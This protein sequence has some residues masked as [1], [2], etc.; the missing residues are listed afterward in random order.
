MAL[1][2]VSS[3]LISSVANTAITGN[4]ISGQITSVANTQITGVLNSSQLANTGVSAGIY[5]GA[6]QIPVIC[7]NNQGQL[8]SVSNSSITLGTIATQNYSNVCITGGNVCANYVCSNT[9]MIAPIICAS[10]CI[11]SPIICA[12]TCFVGS[13][14]GITGINTLGGGS[15][16]TCSSTSYTLTSA[17]CRAIGLCF[18]SLPSIACL[19]LPNATTINSGSPAY[20]VKNLNPST[21]VLVQDSCFCTVGYI[22]SCQVGEISLYNNSQAQGNWAVINSGVSSCV[23]NSTINCYWPAGFSSASCTSF[24]DANNKI[25]TVIWSCILPCVCTITYAP[26]ASGYNVTSTSFTT[27]GCRCACVGIQTINFSYVFQTPD[28]FILIENRYSGTCRALANNYSNTTVFYVIN[29]DS[30]SYTKFT[31]N[32]L[33]NTSFCG[34]G[35]CTFC[36][37]G[38]SSY[39]SQYTCVFN[40]HIHLV[41]YGYTCSGNTCLLHLDRVYYTVTGTTGTP[42]MCSVFTYCSFDSWLCTCGGGTPFCGTAMLT[43]TVGWCSVPNRIATMYQQVWTSNSASYI[44]NPVTTGFYA[45]PIAHKLFCYYAN[46]CVSLSCVPYNSALDNGTFNCYNTYA[47]TIGIA[48]I[49]Y[50]AQGMFM[51]NICGTPIITFGGGCY[52]GVVTA[53]STGYYC[54]SCIGI[55]CSVAAGYECLFQLN[56][57]TANS[58]LFFVHGTNSFC[59][60]IFRGDFYE[61]CC[62]CPKPLNCLTASSFT[63]GSNQHLCCCCYSEPWVGIF[64]GS[65][66]PTCSPGGRYNYAYHYGDKDRG[67]TLANPGCTCC[68]QC[69]TPTYLLYCDTPTCAVFYGQGNCCAPGFT[70]L[71]IWTYAPGTA[72]V[73]GCSIYLN[74]LNTCASCACCSYNIT[75]SAICCPCAGGVQAACSGYT[76][77]MGTLGVICSYSLQ[78]HS[79]A[80]NICGYTCLTCV[81]ICAKLN[82]CMGCSCAPACAVVYVPYCVGANTLLNFSACGCTTPGLTGSILSYNIASYPAVVTCLG[83]TCGP[84]CNGILVD[85]N[86]STGNY[87]AVLPGYY[88]C[89]VPICGPTVL[90][91]NYCYLTNTLTNNYSYVCLS[92]VCLLNSCALY[93]N[94]LSNQVI[95]CSVTT[96]GCFV[97]TFTKVKLT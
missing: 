33:G 15:T 23:V 59:P 82:Y 47:G 43:P 54:F 3:G 94:A 96:P 58:N 74:S 10:S 49:C 28:S 68:L 11:I 24:L 26:T 20:T 16:I 97:A 75:T 8:T 77:C 22:S 35:I 71:A 17:D 72:P 12:S 76:L 36:C 39:N 70:S 69:F 37:C 56:R 38:G 84:V 21:V 1:T 13:G 31:D 48:A 2:Q 44:F 79:F 80:A 45:F 93:A 78:G 81:P 92:Y 61:Y 83:A 25:H 62:A 88:T 50:C 85:Y 60:A 46:G 63:F 73:V 40:N 95:L 27:C 51:C 34:V 18:S 53:N 7:V 30:T 29:C 5:G 89:C 66:D 52:Y 41:D 19:I 67:C 64:G 4:I 14:A 90:I 65:G 91:G 9:C 57:V 42:T 6:T 32:T 55:A 86:T 87:I